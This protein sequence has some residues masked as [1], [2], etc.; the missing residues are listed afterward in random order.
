MLA[1]AVSTARAEFRS[2]A[3]RRRAVRRA[4]DGL[5]VEAVEL[6]RVFEQRRIAARAHGFENRRD[7]VLRLRPGGRFAACEQRLRQSV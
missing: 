6:A 1:A 4:R 5:P 2:Q 7:H 3:A